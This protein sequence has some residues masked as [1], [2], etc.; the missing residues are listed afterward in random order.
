M[1]KFTIEEAL[2]HAEQYEKNEAISTAAKVIRALIEDRTSWK[3]AV[4]EA[5]IVYHIDWT[6]GDPKA[7]LNRLL[8][9]NAQM[10]LDPLISKEAQDLIER[11]HKDGFETYEKQYATRS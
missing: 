10:A 11:G 3:E 9:L 5:C 6:E 1:A 4:I 7:T 8:A 2:Y